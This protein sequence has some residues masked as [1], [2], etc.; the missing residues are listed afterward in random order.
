M[1][2]KL[3]L[4]PV[5]PWSYHAFDW[6]ETFS[7]SLLRYIRSGD[8]WLIR[9]ELQEGTQFVLSP[10]GLFRCCSKP[11][12]DGSVVRLRR[13]KAKGVW[14]EYPPK[15]FTDRRISPGTRFKINISKDEFLLGW[16]ESDSLEGICLSGNIRIKSFG[17]HWK[18]KQHGDNGV[19]WN[20]TVTMEIM[21]P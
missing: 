1:T 10:E 2:K 11:T 5:I 18:A 19:L 21:N 6:S 16:F 12:P 4:L 7:L 3:E 15:Y 14:A 20:H 17:T 8:T 13:R 9:D